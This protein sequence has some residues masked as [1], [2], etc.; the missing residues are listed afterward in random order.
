MAT[1]TVTPAIQF[2][3]GETVTP[4]KLN[5]AA[6]P[7]AT[8]AL[9]D[10]EVTTGKIADRAVT[11]GKLDGIA[12]IA[13]KTADYTLV[14]ADAGRVIEFNSAS[15]LTLTVPTNATAAFATGATIIVTRRGAG[16]VTVAG[17]SGVTLRSDGSKAR[18]RNQYT[19]A[20]L[21][22]IGTDE[23]LLAGNLKT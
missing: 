23:W 1:V 21:V 18:L 3:S 7:T 16:E 12:D 6:T 20:S 10:G 4:A 22:K 2:I 8:A 11:A 13:G 19:A 17:A 14:L 15:D 9:E 5:S